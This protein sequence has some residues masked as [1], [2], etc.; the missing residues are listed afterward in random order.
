VR[1]PAGNRLAERLARL[2]QRSY[3]R[4]RPPDVLV[5]LR[6]EPEVAVA[7]RTDEDADFVR[8]RNREVWEADWAATAAHVVD[9]S[10]PADDVLAEVKSVV[11]AA[12]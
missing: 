4:L 11:W 1:P 7:R 9:A 12:L 3:E 2:E 5:V 10:R 8:T 6:L